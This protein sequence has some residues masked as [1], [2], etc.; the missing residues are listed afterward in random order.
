MVHIRSFRESA[1][2]LCRQV[3]EEEIARLMKWQTPETFTTS[4]IMSLVGQ[5]KGLSMS[6]VVDESFYDTTDKWPTDKLDRGM[7][8]T[9]TYCEVK[10]LRTFDIL[11]DGSYT[12]KQMTGGI[13]ANNLFIKDYKSNK[14]LD[15][16]RSTDD[17]IFVA[18]DLIGGSGERPTSESEF[19][20]CDGMAGLRSMVADFFER[21]KREDPL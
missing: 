14:G 11:P 20:V 7:F 12:S 4:E 15:I 9:I 19:W 6:T 18:I 16:F 3:T 2:Q 21:R 8:W 13:E 10:L 17:W 5:L 1:G